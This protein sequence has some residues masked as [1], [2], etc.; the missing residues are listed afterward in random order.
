MMDEH[1]STRVNPANFTILDSGSNDI[2]LKILETLHT[3]QQ[4]P[5]IVKKET[6]L[7]LRLPEMK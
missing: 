3:I 1:G 7:M 5:T 4:R 2:N 6:S